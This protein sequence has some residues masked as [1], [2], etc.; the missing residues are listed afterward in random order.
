MFKR[1]WLFIKDVARHMRDGDLQ[2]IVYALS[3]VTLISVIPLMVVTLGVFKWSGYLN[4]L[5]PKVEALVISNLSVFTVDD[6]SKYLKSFLK[7]SYAGGFGFAN[8]TLL[9]FT[10]QRLV[11]DFEKAVNRLWNVKT[12][13]NIMKRFLIHW[14]IISLVPV[15]LAADVLVKSFL[16]AYLFDRKQNL[17]SLSFLFLFAVLFALMKLI[18]NVKVKAKSALAGALTASIGFV[19]LQSSFGWITQK[20]FVYS[21]FYGSLAALPLFMIWVSSIWFVILFGVSLSSTL[22]RRKTD[23]TG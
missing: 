12:P 19:V 7:R 4:F 8:V 21:K 23:R 3:F 1:L 9:L 13:R 15:A 11:S 18:P 5:Y 17:S 20:S 2:L 10:S 22:Q 16:S 14:M 6:I